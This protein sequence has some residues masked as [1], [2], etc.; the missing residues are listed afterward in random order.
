[1]KRSF[2]QSNVNRE[3][4]DKGKKG[5]CELDK[6]EPETR[7][8]DPTNRSEELNQNQEI[9]F[10]DEAEENDAN[11]DGKPPRKEKGRFS[12]IWGHFDIR[13]AD[14]QKTKYAHCHYCIRYN[15]RLNKLNFFMMDCNLIK[16]STS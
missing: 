10:D 16:A 7:D 9:E 15:L 8:F 12:W 4:K 6:E 1:M 11:E 3:S 5:R 13:L 2:E 14:D